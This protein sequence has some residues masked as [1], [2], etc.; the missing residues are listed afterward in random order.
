MQTRAA[1]AARPSG[2][3]RHVQDENDF[4]PHEFSVRTPGPRQLPPRNSDLVDY[5]LL[6]FTVATMWTVLHNTRKYAMQVFGDMAGWIARHPSS[7]MR[8]W[9]LGDVT[10]E[11]LKRYIGLCITWD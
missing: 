10:L 2:G 11:L 3:W 6:L 5:F 8:R 1:A 4:T 9:S 7:R